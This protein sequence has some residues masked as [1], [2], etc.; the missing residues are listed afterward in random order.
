MVASVGRGCST[1][2]GMFCRS[3]L[4]VWGLAIGGM[5]IEGL[6]FFLFWHGGHPRLLVVVLLVPQE[7]PLIVSF[8][9]SFVCEGSMGGF[10]V[11]LAF[12]APFFRVYFLGLLKPAW[13]WWCGGAHCWKRVIPGGL[14]SS[15]CCGGSPLFSVLSFVTVG[16]WVIGRP[17]NGSGGGLLELLRYRFLGFLV[18]ALLTVHSAQWQQGRGLRVLGTNCSLHESEFRLCPEVVLDWFTRFADRGCARLADS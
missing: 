18:L 10:F 14:Y 4:C 2:S 7:P 6:S 3:R 15:R 17:R 12:S 9:V 13:F 1:L 5:S 8:V 11:F 16:H